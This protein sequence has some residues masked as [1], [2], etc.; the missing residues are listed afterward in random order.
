MTLQEILQV[1]QDGGWVVL[2]IYFLYKEVWPLVTNKII[3]AT[4]KSVEEEKKARL[5]ELESDR[6]FHREMETERAKTLNLI[7]NA[8]QELSKAMAETGSMQTSILKNQEHIMRTQDETLSILNSA[9]RQMTEVTSE[10]LGYEKGK[11][12]HKKG[13]TGPLSSDQK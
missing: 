12:E 10:R 4:L 13:D 6:V 2:V 5:N 1:V 11:R 9:I 8:I 7:T 3:P